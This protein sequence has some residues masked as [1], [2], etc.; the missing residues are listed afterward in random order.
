MAAGRS[1][2]GAWIFVDWGSTNFR[3]FLSQ[4]GRVVDRLEVAGHGILTAWGEASATARAVAFGTFLAETLRDWLA[5]HS[6]CPLLLCGAIGSREGWVET[7]YV[8]APAGFAEVTAGVRVLDP[9]PAGPLAGRRIAI[10]AGVAQ[11]SADGRHDVMRSEEVKALGAAAV[12]GRCDGVLC[13]PGT[14]CK[15]IRI[16]AGR[17]VALQTVMTGDVFGALSAGHSFA[18]LLAAK[19]EAQAAERLA[20]FDQGLALA[21]QG[22][23]LLRDIWQVRAVTLH[24]ARPPADLRAFLSGILIG[25]EMRERRAIWPDTGEVLL[26]C[27]HGERQQFYCRAAAAFG[28]TVAAV[29]DSETAVCTGLAHVAGRLDGGGIEHGAAP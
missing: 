15:W 2:A 19:P 27:D 14:H 3:A 28:V 18:P 8:E 25:H 4:G 1:G 29:V 13:I 11:A 21:G 16:E 20:S 26:V 7:R 24:A 6:G 23:D 10:V 22:G 12:L 5:R 9:L 17:I